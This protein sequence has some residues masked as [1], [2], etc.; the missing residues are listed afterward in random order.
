MLEQAHA[1]EKARAESEEEQPSSGGL[2]ASVAGELTR[3]RS[4]DP[5]TTPGCLERRWP[6]NVGAR[7][8]CGYSHIR[9]GGDG[10][11]EAGTAKRKAENA[12]ASG[13]CR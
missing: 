6:Q 12:Q 8:T 5:V 1:R 2:L 9:T 7:L 3:R 11:V 10:L 13:K 4:P